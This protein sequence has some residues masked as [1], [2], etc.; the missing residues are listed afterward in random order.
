MQVVKYKDKVYP[1]FQTVGNASQF[2]IPYAK[3]FCKGIGYDIG[4]MKPEWAFP[5]A[6]PIDLDFDDPWHADNL[7]EDQVDYIFSSHCLEHV[8]DWIETLLYWTKKIKSG[9]TLFLYLPH[10]DQEYWRPWNNRK[11]KHVFLPD[12]LFDFMKDVGY[13]DIFVSQRDLNHSFIIV[14]EKA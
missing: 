11:H 10:Y 13:T 3:H 12:M 5:N 4:C 9:G 6:T 14:G 8:P 1:H 7:P 2:A